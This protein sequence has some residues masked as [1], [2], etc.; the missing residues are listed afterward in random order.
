MSKIK[1]IIKTINDHCESMEF[2]EARRMIELNIEEL[3]IS[4]NYFSLNSN[5]V[6]LLK[7]IL[8]QEESTVVPLTRLEMLQINEI[9]KHCTN[10]DISMLKRTIKNSLPLLQRPDIT[11]HLNENAK[12]ILESMGAFIQNEIEQHA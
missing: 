5:A 10:F 7:Y 2:G 12:T 8:N 1:Q 9:N 3:Q 6:V 4:S 11:L